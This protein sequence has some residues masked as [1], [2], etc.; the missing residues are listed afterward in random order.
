MILHPSAL[1]MAVSHPIR[2][3][4]YG[5]RTQVPIDG[6]AIKLEIVREARIALH[7]PGPKDVICGIATLTPLDLAASTLLANSDRQADDGVFSR[8]VIDLAMMNLQLPVLRQ[9]LAKAE[10]AYGLAVTRDLGKAIDRLQVRTGWLDRCMQAM[11]INTVP[12]ALLWQKIRRLR[13]VLP[14]G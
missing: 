4:Q 1:P 3:D 7:P 12:K 8:D 9:A 11:A 2:A 13:R 6:Q 10:Q 5:I 14:S